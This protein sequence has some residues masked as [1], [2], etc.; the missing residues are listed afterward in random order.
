MGSADVCARLPA[1]V[2]PSALATVRNGASN[3]TDATAAIVTVIRA[4]HACRTSLLA[5]VQH[6]VHPR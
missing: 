5:G 6:G 3:A 2:C 4:Q 1:G